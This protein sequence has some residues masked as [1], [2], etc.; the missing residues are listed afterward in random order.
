LARGMG[1][2]PSERVLAAFAYSGARVL[3]CPL[4]HVLSNILNLPPGSIE[5]SEDIF[6]LCDNFVEI[7]VCE[8]E[9]VVFDSGFSGENAGQG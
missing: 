8:Y 3:Q 1:D 7:S 9:D 6:V 4:K 5:L 2:A